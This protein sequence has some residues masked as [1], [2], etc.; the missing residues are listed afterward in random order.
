[1]ILPTTKVLRPRSPSAD[2]ESSESNL[3]AKK[4]IATKV[5]KLSQL[6]AMPNFMISI[7]QSNFFT[8]TVQQIK[9]KTLGG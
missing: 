9:E 7:C 8:K 1:M 2:Y 4:A 6:V 3:E 5:N